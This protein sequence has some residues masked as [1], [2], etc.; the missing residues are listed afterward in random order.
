MAASRSGSPSSLAGAIDA[1]VAERVHFE[2]SAHSRNGFGRNGRRA[3]VVGAL[4]NLEAALERL[5][6][7]MHEEPHAVV[8][9]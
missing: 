3:A 7:A 4:Q 6:D 1:V 5:R 8:T 9:S 2:T